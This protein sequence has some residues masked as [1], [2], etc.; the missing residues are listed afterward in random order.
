MNKEQFQISFQKALDR[1]VSAFARVYKIDTTPI[2]FEVHA[3]TTKGNIVTEAEAIDAIFLSE[4]MF[5]KI[6]DV[7]VILR[8]NAKPIGFIRVSGHPPCP[9]EETLNPQDLGPFK[10]LGPLTR[11]Q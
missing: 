9:Y 8:P 1:A 7:A 5:Y 11:R 4:S 2:C 10:S 6:I 3:P